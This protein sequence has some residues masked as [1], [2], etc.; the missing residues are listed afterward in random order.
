MQ[1]FVYD[2]I[3][4]GSVPF[5]VPKGTNYLNQKAFLENADLAYGELLFQWKVKVF[6]STSFYRKALS[7]IHL[8]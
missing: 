5:I 4:A 8:Q 7:S 6:K 1:A 2:N 3:Y